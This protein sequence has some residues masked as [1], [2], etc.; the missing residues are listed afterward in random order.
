MFKRLP[1][2]RKALVEAARGLRPLDLAVKNVNLVNVLTCEIYP[3]DIGVYGGRFA[4]IGPAGEYDLKAERE[5]DGSGKWACPGFF[6]A[7]LHIESTMVTPAGYAKGVLPLG[8]TS[9]VIDPHEIGNVMGKEGVRLMIEGSRGLPLRVYVAVPS[10]VPSVLGAETAGATFGPAEVAEMMQWERVISLA[11]V[12][13]YIGVVNNDERMRG[14]VDAAL[15]H[16]GVVQGHAPKLM[17]R[18][19]NAY[20]AA[21]IDN[22]HESRLGE[23]VLEKLRLGLLPL[24]KLG[25]PGNHL[26]RLMPKLLEAEYVDVAL[27]TD[28][29]EPSDLLL[30]GHMD[31]VVRG[32]MEYGVPVTR[33]LRWACYIGPQHY[34]LRDFGAIAPGFIAD[35]LLLDSLEEV[36]TSDVFIEGRQVVEDRKLVEPIADPLAG[37]E[38]R[39]TVNISAIETADFHIA[40]PIEDGRITVNAL[41]LLPNRMTRIAPLELAVEKGVIRPEVLPEGWVMVSVVPRHGQGTRPVCVPLTGVGLTSGAIAHTV[42][43]DCHNILVAGRSAGD[44]KAAVEALKAMGG[45][46]V[47]VDQG[48]V[49]AE[50]PLPFAGLMSFESCEELSERIAFYNNEIRKRGVQ[51]ESARPIMVLTGL[52]LAVIPEVRPTDIYPLFDVVT[53]KPIPLFELVS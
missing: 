16:G 17:G 26:P 43:H 52:P 24:I 41:E 46:F 9:A 29:V 23:E 47:L 33:A 18:D 42:A 49:V 1:T 44:M 6:D 53:Q 8:T 51:P 3:A 7:H 32:V 4:V 31:R 30:N 45:G 5:I 22:D 12:M 15:A 28:D 14:I 40:A 37:R 20:I 27:C 35:F 13:D 2:D 10:C 34:G 11:E 50:V 39:D 36:R 19:L 48:R 25:S 38:I 21:G